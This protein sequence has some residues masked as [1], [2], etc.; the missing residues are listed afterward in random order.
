MVGSFLN[1][2]IHRLPGGKSIVF[3]PSS[4]PHCNAAIAFYDN[5]PIISYIVLLGRCRQCKS[6]ISP[7]YPLVEFLTGFFSVLLLKT[8]GFSIEFPVYFVFAAS[9]IVITFIDL[10]HQIIPDVIS[11]PGIVVGFL[12]SCFLPHGILNSAIGILAGGGSLFLIAFGYH[13]VTGREGM[14]GGDIKLLAMIGAF[15]GW[16]SVIITIFTGSFIG[17]VVGSALML[18]KGKDTKYAIPFGPFLAFGAIISLFFGETII[19]WYIMGM[20]R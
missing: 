10:Q 16:K 7:R 17:A 4:C 13:F 5:I 3:P 12:V 15:L 1:V 20:G 14:G 19:K 9:L 8:F 11:L 18:A 2:C 6:P